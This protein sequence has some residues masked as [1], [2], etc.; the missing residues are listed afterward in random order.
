MTSERGEVYRERMRGA[1][2]FFKSFILGEEYTI[3]NSLPYMAGNR[4]STQSHDVISTHYIIST[5]GSYKRG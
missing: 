4:E 3:L 1:L 2:K 5:W